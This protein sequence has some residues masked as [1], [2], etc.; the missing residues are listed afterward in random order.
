MFHMYENTL[1]Y[2]SYR[3]EQRILAN[4]IACNQE[5]EQDW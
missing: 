1:K 5:Q 2:F 3:V 4:Y